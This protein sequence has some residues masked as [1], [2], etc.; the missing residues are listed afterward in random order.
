M[1]NLPI[2][3]SKNDKSDYVWSE[4]YKNERVEITPGKL[5]S[6]QQTSIDATLF[7]T[8]KVKDE[9]KAIGTMP[10]ARIGMCL[11]GVHIFKNGDLVENVRANLYLRCNESGWY[12]PLVPD[13]R[14]N[15]YIPDG[16]AIESQSKT[17]PTRHIGY[18]SCASSHTTH[19]D[20]AEIDMRVYIKK[21][22]L[23]RLQKLLND[24]FTWNK[25][26]WSIENGIIKV[27]SS[28]TEVWD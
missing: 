16:G 11:T 18:G 15:V 4:G 6:G 26:K 10:D 24:N 20:Y 19:H 5:A 28:W 23:E 22:G 27:N 2:L 1:F 13:G 8:K 21:Y 25:S 12:I 3:Y 14:K 17:D 9:L 7:L